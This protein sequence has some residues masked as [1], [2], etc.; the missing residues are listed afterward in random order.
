VGGNVTVVGVVL[1]T[2][3]VNPVPLKVPVVVRGAF[4]APEVVLVAVRNP[5]LPPATVGVNVT[6]TE[7]L[8]PAASV[9][10]QV[11]ELIAKS[12]PAG[13]E[14]ARLRPDSPTPLGLETVIVIPALVVP[15]PVPGKLSAVGV[16]LNCGGVSPVPDTGVCT[17]VTPRLVVDTVTVPLWLPAEV[18]AKVTG[19]T[20]I[21]PAARLVP[22]LPDPTLKGA[23]VEIDN[24]CSVPVPGLFTVSCCDAPLVPTVTEPKVSAAGV[25]ASLAAGSPV[26]ASPTRTGVNPGVLDWI[27]TDPIRVPAV[28][29]ENVTEKLHIALL[30]NWDPQSLPCRL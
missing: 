7:Q 9:E 8:P 17:A 29:G 22:Q 2:A 10:E 30:A 6:T 19:A 14:R 26:P 27:V 23:A 16:R 3:G 13:P 12:P 20:H 28:D 4:P 1:S 25:T 15:T 21:A 5:C 18:G 11:V 24:P